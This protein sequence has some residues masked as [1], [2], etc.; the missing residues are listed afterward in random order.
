MHAQTIASTT[1]VLATALTT[2]A[3][4]SGKASA[5]Q[6]SLRLELPEAEAVALSSALGLLPALSNE[7][8]V[9]ISNALALRAKVSGHYSNGSSQ[10]RYQA[11]VAAAGARVSLVGA[12]AGKLYVALKGVREERHAGVLESASRR[13]ELPSLGI[14]CVHSRG[15]N[16]YTCDVRVGR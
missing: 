2:L 7:I 15:W 9:V 14:A 1:R 5:Q 8:A 10:F 12:Q 6:A 3:L 13:L 11:S 16:P 4:A